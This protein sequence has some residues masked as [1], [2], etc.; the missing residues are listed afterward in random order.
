MINKNRLW[1]IILG[2]TGSFGFAAAKLL[3]SRGYNL[4]LVYRERKANLL[5]LNSELELLNQNCDL[6]TFNLNANEPENQNLIIDALLKR[7]ELKNKISFLLH[8]IA[9]GNL[10]PL[11]ANESLSMED[12]N[13][14]IQSMGTSMYLWTRLLHKNDFF[15]KN[16]SVLGLTSE[17]VN[18]YFHNYAA[19]ASAK[20]VMESNMKYM[21][22]E[23]AK[24]G[25]RA[26][27]ISAGIADTKALKA[28]PNYEFF[29]ENAKKRNPQKRLTTPEDVAKVVGF[30]ASDDS[31]WINGTILTVD[32]GE[33][34]INGLDENI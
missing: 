31:I 2:G 27:L 30:M 5:N 12:F 19:V 17:G 29:I 10:K 4:I 15:A 34:L 24:Y 14:T 18:R 28:F 33:Q 21:A 13:H 8:A 23:L 32:G 16:S 9:D 6:I 1:A 3:A 22:V 26:N 11:F 25:I 20:S 7:P